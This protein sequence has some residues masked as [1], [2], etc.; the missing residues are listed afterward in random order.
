MGTSVNQVAHLSAA[1]AHSNFEF[2]PLL[3]RAWALDPYRGGPFSYASLS[4]EVECCPRAGHFGLAL[5]ARGE[6]CRSTFHYLSRDQDEQRGVLITRW[7]PHGIERA[8]VR[9]GIWILCTHLS[10]NIDERARQI[11]ELASIV[12]GLQG[13]LLL[14]GDLNEVPTSEVLLPLNQV[15]LCDLFEMVHPAIMASER[16]TFSVKQPN[17]C[18]DYMYGRGIEC[19][20]IEVARSLKG[21]DHFPVWAEIIW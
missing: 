20:R 14:L 17:R 16:W 21:S 15:G 7:Y 10:V 19:R 6:L 18:I 8:E 1:Q 5:S 12:E 3:E 2:L 11:L 13:P 4:D 9:D